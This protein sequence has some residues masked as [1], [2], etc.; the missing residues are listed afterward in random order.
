MI[1]SDFNVICNVTKVLRL[2]LILNLF[3]NK[4]KLMSF[5]IN[6]KINSNLTLY[7][8]DAIY[9]QFLP[10]VQLIVLLEFQKSVSSLWK[11]MTQFIQISLLATFFLYM[12]I[13]RSFH[14]LKFD[15]L[16]LF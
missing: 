9:N 4:K 11:G 3:L 15:K 16:L 13:I 12:Y 7:V 14:T 10:V 5:E 6:I 8:N 1:S 2:F